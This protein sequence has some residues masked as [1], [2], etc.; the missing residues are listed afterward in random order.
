MERSLL[1][2]SVPNMLTIWLMLAGGFILFAVGS[3][4]FKHAGVSMGGQAETDA[5]AF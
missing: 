1:T 3:Q 4:I 5:E 2:W